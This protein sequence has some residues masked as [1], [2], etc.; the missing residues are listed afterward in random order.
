MAIGTFIRELREEAGLSQ[1][2][3]A[4]K[5]HIS[6]PTLIKMEQGDREITLSEAQRAAGLFKLTVQ[7]LMNER[8]PAEPVVE[9]PKKRARRQTTAKPE[10]RISVPQKR[11][12][13]FKQVLLLILS[14][15]G[16]KPNVGETVLNKLLYFVDF[17]FYE[18]YEEQ[19][20]GATYIKNHFGPTSV[21]FKAIVDDMV[22]NKELVPVKSQVFDHE[23]KKYLP[24]IE[25]D[26]SV[27]D[28]RA[29][30]LIEEVLG[31]YADMSARQISELSHRDVPW[32]TAEDGQPL[33]YESV[34]YRTPEF[35]VR[36]YDE[37]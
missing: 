18:K 29:V 24:A 31:R 26:L 12:D 32:L 23:R 34:F 8:R 16:A 5:L 11:L 2:E 37:V 21:E 4:E 22:A 36:D 10:I 15:V 6:R 3:L 7:D 14:Q 1:S 35:S 28:A 9:L 25:P 33:D 13:V 27:L 17:D 19:L 30:Q 20:V